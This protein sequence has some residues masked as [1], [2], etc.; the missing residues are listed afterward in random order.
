MLNDPYGSG[1]EARS[2]GAEFGNPVFRGSIVTWVV[3]AS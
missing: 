1:K 3:D 2:A